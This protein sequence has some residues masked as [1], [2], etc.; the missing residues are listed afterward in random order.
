MKVFYSGAA[1]NFRDVNP[2][3]GGIPYENY[4]DKK[5]CTISAAGLLQKI[6]K[7]DLHISVK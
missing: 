5:E 4:T 7:L 3:S 6:Q 1:L 2:A